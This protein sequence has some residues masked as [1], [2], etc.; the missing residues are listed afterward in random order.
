M[1]FWLRFSMEETEETT[2]LG[3]L[4]TGWKI[5]LEYVLNK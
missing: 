5:I 3:D 1:L 4:G 2:Y